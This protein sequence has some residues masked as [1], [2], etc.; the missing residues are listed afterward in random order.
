MTKE[1]REHHCPDSQPQIQFLMVTVVAT[2]FFAS[3]YCTSLL[4]HRDRVREEGQRQMLEALVNCI[5]SGLIE[6]RE[7]RIAGTTTSDS[8]ENVA[9]ETGKPAALPHRAVMDEGGVR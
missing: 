9:G 5:R 7:D 3:G 2:V 8:G 1:P 4:R 6:V